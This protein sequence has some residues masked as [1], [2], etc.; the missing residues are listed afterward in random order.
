MGEVQGILGHQSITVTSKIYVHYDVRNLREVFDRCS[1]S[2]ED[3]AREMSR[4]D[5]ESDQR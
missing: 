2:P 5:R 1:A 3:V 4:S